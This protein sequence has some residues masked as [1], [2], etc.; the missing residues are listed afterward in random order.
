M[1]VHIK[2]PK[3]LT[4]EQ[5]AT[6]VE[7]IQKG[8]VNARNEL[9]EANIAFAIS[10]ARKFFLGGHGKIDIEQCVSAAL[11]GLIEA[12]ERHDA[13]RGVKFISYAR[14]WVRQQMLTDAKEV[15]TIRIP[16]SRIEAL[17]KQHNGKEHL[18]TKAQK[19]GL[20][21]TRQ[22]LSM[23]SIHAPIGGDD[24]QPSLLSDI[25][26]DEAPIA[27][28][29]LAEAE[30]QHIVQSAVCELA[31]R[32]AGM[33]ECYFGLNGKERQTLSEIGAAY[34]VSKERTRQI[35]ERAKDVLYKNSGGL[36]R[37]I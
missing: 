3:G 8:D 12:A 11:V 35:I 29:L 7:R 5:E 6:L 15:N 30:M 14:W 22:I 28:E 13:S 9:V 4:L 20:E 25:I 31:P 27:D 37:H 10:E 16:H 2:H 34:G 18:L 21:K 33:I 17:S 36:R 26:P 24:R 19:D 1:I 23:A 32:S